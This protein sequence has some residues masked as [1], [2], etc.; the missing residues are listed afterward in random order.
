MG[1]LNPHSCLLAHAKPISDHCPTMLNS[2]NERWGP[3]PFRFKSS[4]LLEDHF[5]DMIR[6]WWKDITVD[7]WAGYRHALKLK[8]VKIRIKEWSVQ[9]YGNVEQIKPR[10]L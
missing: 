6:N 5:P 10:I 3:G 4:W 9:H 8:K 2:K 1:R 7:G